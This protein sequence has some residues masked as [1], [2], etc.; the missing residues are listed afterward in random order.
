MNCAYTS[1]RADS[2]SRFCSAADLPCARATRRAAR[3]AR[4]ASAALV[5]IWT[6]IWSL[7]S[8]AAALMKVPGP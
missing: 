8:P 4:A 7:I 3:A 2:P 6:W 1:W 5:R